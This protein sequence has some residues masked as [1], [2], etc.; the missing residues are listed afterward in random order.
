MSTPPLLSEATPK[1]KSPGVLAGH[2]KRDDRLMRKI[3]R[4]VE[5]YVEFKRDCEIE[6]TKRANE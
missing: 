6:L 5:D 2:L 1:P 4:F 3:E